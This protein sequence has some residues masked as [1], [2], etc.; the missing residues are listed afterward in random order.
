MCFRKM[1]GS[2]SQWHQQCDVIGFMQGCWLARLFYNCHCNAQCCCQQLLLSCSGPVYTAAHPGIVP[3]VWK[4]EILKRCVKRQMWNIRMWSWQL[5]IRIF[6]VTMWLQ[7]ASSGCAHCLT[8]DLKR[9][10]MFWLLLSHNNTN[11]SYKIAM[12]KSLEDAPSRCWL[13]CK[14]SK[15]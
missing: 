6:A 13:W 2:D 3:H 15:F 14:L 8:P 9:S 12:H 11:K 4:H 10:M 7:I 1:R 5:R